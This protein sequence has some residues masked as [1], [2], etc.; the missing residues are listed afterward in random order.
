MVLAAAAARTTAIRLTSA[1]T[2]LGVADPVRAF[3]VCTG[4]RPL[5]FTDGLLQARDRAR[6]F[7]RVDQQI[8]VLS[9]PDLQAADELLDR[10]RAHAPP[11]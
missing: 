11:A 9:R 3:S 10:L 2:L 5:F 7:F 4:G 8:Q 1:T 6:W